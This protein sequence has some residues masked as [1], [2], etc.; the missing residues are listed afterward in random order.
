VQSKLKKKLTQKLQEARASLSRGRS[1]V[2]TPD[3]SRTTTPVTGNSR[4]T[5]PVQSLFERA[6]AFTGSPSP[7]Q[8]S[9]SSRSPRKSPAGKAPTGGGDEEYVA[10]PGVTPSTDVSTRA[11][12]KNPKKP[13][14]KRTSC[15]V[16]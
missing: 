16:M 8:V 12:P 6:R 5:T 11:A 10:T 14:S 13:P 1:P 9:P 2:G 3:S 15:S 4:S 7:V